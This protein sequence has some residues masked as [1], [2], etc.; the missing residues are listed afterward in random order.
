MGYHELI[1]SL[2]REGEEKARAIR[3]AVEAE[4]VRIRGESAG[5]IEALRHDYAR[6]RDAAEAAEAG[7]IFAEAQKKVALVRLE[8]ES[9][10]AGRLYVVACASLPEL[11]GDGYAELF[12]A[13]AAE[14]PPG[15][16]ETVRV[17]PADA[18]LAKECFPAAQIETESGITG[19]FDLAAEGGRVRID[20]TLETRLERGWPEL[21][22]SLMKAVAQ[23]V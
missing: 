21:L 11:R 17:N 19:G 15:Q 6:R 7:A 1:D 22:P 9:A 8:A 10:L 12:A 2:S 3:L 16:W 13:L 23:E 14:L 20:N 18:E 5:R 4:A